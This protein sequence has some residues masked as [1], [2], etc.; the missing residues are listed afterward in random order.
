[1]DDLIRLFVGRT[2]EM[3]FAQLQPLLTAAGITSLD[4]VTSVDQLA[5]LQQDI[6][7]GN[8]GV[9]LIP[10]DAYETPFSPEQ[11]QLPNSFAFTGQRFVPDGWALGQVTFDR[12]KWNE[13]IPFF[14]VFG[15]VIRRYPSAL[16][17][18]YGVLGN[19]QIGWEIGQRMLDTA[20]RTNF[21]D[22]LPYAHNLTAVAAT[23]DRLSPAA[24][25]DSI[26]TRWLAALRTLSAPT[27]D[28]RFPQ[29]MRTPGL[30]NADAQHPVGLVHRA[31]TRYGPFT[32]S[33]P[34]AL[35]FSVNIPRVCRARPGILATDER[36]G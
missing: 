15:K 22:G 26:Y 30:G 13:E 31:E 19:R 18:A 2:D 14:T 27:T 23:F 7:Q 9:Q 32:P 25:D 16:D 28:E 24:W 8:L 12:I 36:A 3:T 21:R 35:S 5:K 1:L 6:V 29:A 10:G 33:S 34:T 11:V 4:A 20:S 17:V